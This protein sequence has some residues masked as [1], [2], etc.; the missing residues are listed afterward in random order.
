LFKL[1]KK[2]N[3]FFL[4]FI[5]ILFIFLIIIA[6]IKIHMNLI[7]R[8]S[9]PKEETIAKEE[10]SPT[11]SPKD[12]T[13]MKQA[14]SI[15][16]TKAIS[17]DA[18]LAKIIST[19]ARVQPSEESGANGTRAVWNVTF[20]DT[21]SKSEYNIFVSRDKAEILEDKNKVVRKAISDSDIKIDSSDAIKIAKEQK[22]L[23]PGIPH[24]SFA[25][26]YHFNL[27]YDSSDGV[28][29]DNLII[30]VI[31]ISPKGNF[32]HVNIDANNG[33]IIASSE[34]TYDENG[35]GIWTPF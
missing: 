9:S 14:I 35:K 29:N 11:S 1:N 33:N 25:I 5:C 23:K 15:A 32:A 24:K 16:Y 2:K 28:P 30:Q 4:A 20:T 22:Q 34:K 6:S 10:I 27:Y 31:G 21:T 18:K 7:S 12:E 26:G 19:D 17:P 3:I 13:T 8:A